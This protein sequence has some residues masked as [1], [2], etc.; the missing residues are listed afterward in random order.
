MANITVT[1][2]AEKNNNIDEINTNIDECKDQI[3][4]V[5]GAS[6]NNIEE[7]VTKQSQLKNIKSFY[8]YA[9]TIIDNIDKLKDYYLDTQN[10]IK[11]KTTGEEATIKKSLISSIKDF[12]ENYSN[13][14]EKFEIIEF[15]TK[16]KIYKTK[17]EGIILKDNLEMEK[18]DKF[19]DI[20]LDILNY[21]MKQLVYKILTE[22]ENSLIKKIDSKSMQDYYKAAV[23]NVTNRYKTLFLDKPDV[24]VKDI[25][26]EEKKVIPKVEKVEEKNKIESFYPEILR[27]MVKCGF[28]NK[29]YENLPKKNKKLIDLI[30]N[31]EDLGNKTMDERKNEGKEIEKLYKKIIKRLFIMTAEYYKR[32]LKNKKQLTYQSIN[33]SYQKKS[34]KGKFKSLKRSG[35]QVGDWLP[36]IRKRTKKNKSQIHLGDDYKIDPI[37]GATKWVTS[38]SLEEL[39]DK[40]G[41][42]QESINNMRKKIK[43]LKGKLKDKPRSSYEW[44]EYYDLKKILRKEIRKLY[45]I[46]YFL[47]KKAVRIKRNKNFLGFSKKGFKRTKLVNTINTLRD[48]IIV[49]L[50]TLKFNS[51]D[52]SNVTTFKTQLRNNKNTTTEDIFT[53]PSE[54]K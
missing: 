35:K 3:I 20:F 27:F 40:S 22:Y 53:Q 25:N 31:L 49:D 36:L 4:K 37:F 24:G 16:E 7:S 10:S 30:I 33:N 21:I 1:A 23:D 12:N 29:I 42:V 45:V 38:K 14:L 54:T 6:T 32:D 8:N 34:I 26:N 48:K 41:A 15:K 46:R 17:K 39:Q 44:Y 52:K 13:I 5:I 28:D 9:K 2:S 11:L 19:S 50:R 43:E 51:S 47:L 18:R